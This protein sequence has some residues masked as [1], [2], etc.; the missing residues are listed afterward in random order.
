MIHYDITSLLSG[1]NGTG[2]KI[3]VDTFNMTNKSFD[4]RIKLI[5]L[6]LAYDDG[7]DDSISYFVNSNQLWS[8][9]DV[10]V[11]FDTE[12][13]TDI[14]RTS[15]TNIVLSSGDGTYRMND[16]L[17]GDASE[18][19]T[20]N[21]FYYQYNK[22]NDVTSLIKASQKNTLNVAY[23]GTSTY[24][25]IKNVISVLTVN[26]LVADLSLTTEYTSVPCAYAGTNNT[27]T[28]TVKTNKAGQY[29]VKL[30]ADGTMVSQSEANLT[31][32]SNTVFITDPTVRAVDETTV[33]GA[34][35]NNV[36][37]AVQLVYK[38]ETLAA[39]STILPI[40]YNG[41]LGKDLAYPAGGFD[42]A[43]E[44]IVNGDI[45]VDVKDASSYLGTS[46]MNRTD[47]WAVNLDENSTVVK[48]FVYIPYNWFNGKLG[49]EDVNMFNVTFNG[50][51]VTPIG[52]YRDQGNLGKYGTYGYGV[53]V[54][55][56]TDLVNKSGD[57]TLTL[58]KNQATPA[59][60]PSVLVYMYDKTESNTT[61]QI[62]IVNGADLISNDYNKAGRI[63]KADSTIKTYSKFTNNATLYVFAAG[64]QAGEGN[65]VFNGETYEN[66]WSG[67]DKTTDL[68]T[69]NVTGN[70]KD[71]NAVSF[72]GTGS[73][74]LA[75][76]QMIV[77]TKDSDG[78]SVSLAP[79]YT[80]VPCVYAGTNNAITITIDVIKSGKY[81]VSLYDGLT[82][83]VNST[84][85]DL[86]TGTNKVVLIDPTIRPV[87]ETTVNGAKNK[88]VTYLVTLLYENK[89][90]ALN[91]TSLPILYNG[92]LGKDLEYNAK[93]IE[94]TTVYIVSGN[95][96]ISPKDDST[97]MSAAATNRT[98][99][100]DLEL[101]KGHSFDTAFV[102]IAY[103]WDKSGASG[104]VFN[105]TFN[106]KT[107]TPKAHY[108][109]QSNLGKYG[110]YGYGLFVY[111]VS[112]LIKEGNN[113]LVLNKES[114]LTAVYPSSL[115]FLTNAP[116]FDKFISVYI[117][118]GA[119]LISN[120]NNNAGRLVA[121]HSKFTEVDASDVKGAKFAVFAA[122]A[123]AGD[124]NIVFNG[125]E[126]VNVWNGT[127]NSF[128]VYLKD[129]TDSVNQTNT[130]SF[131][132]TG[133]TILAL[134]QILVVNQK[135]LLLAT[136]KALSTT[137]DS[138]KSFTVTVTDVNEVPMAGVK[139]NIAVYTNA[140]ATTYHAT[141]NAKG[142]A[143]LSGASRLAIGT[144]KVVI[145]I[146]T[147]DY[148][149]DTIT[150]AIKVAKAKTIVKAPKVTAKVKK[151]KYFKV[152]VI[153]KATKKAVKG[154]K[155]KV[156]VYTGKKYKTYTIKTKSKGIA[157]LNT[158]YFKV[159]THKVIITSGNAK[160]TIAA[161]SSIVIKK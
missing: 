2:L 87:N 83:K 121:T 38:D 67:T 72:V 151:S 111:D 53:L 39:N 46:A 23:A 101:P 110:N 71:S 100:W 36:T 5:A 102:Y 74:I 28:V 137:Y 45:V 124:G 97:Y 79:E 17:I 123:N 80:S 85:V 99:V 159:G 106:G 73:T 155:V 103:N 143:T 64:A 65:I 26:N 30:F 63:V 44:F 6:V 92:N 127:S 108:R 50:A 109:D 156:K 93:Y 31:N 148:Y 125:V 29:A 43:I 153:N 4:G 134:S 11:T 88:N 18:H 81:T 78:A 154:I 13:L 126:D 62:Y 7:D 139:L 161:K 117:A 107:I 136:P 149:M 60:Y 54:Y 141:T 10:N 24:G 90:A 1:L 82:K 115:L 9:S 96:G 16:E 147:S 144:H 94:N 35:N 113:T 48:S 52:I 61:K 146:G 95:V 130:V 158:K 22:W 120:A 86:I 49:T 152:K 14:G 76:P 33:S 105:V 135:A 34:E 77:L 59:V 132:G 69:V 55:D 131:V 20:G 58:N 89:T 98:D 47:V 133:S 21:D 138:G 114:G 15:L 27:L 129:V 119:D 51:N 116:T 19:S 91:Y 8:K 142:V 68:Y 112:D 150:S 145:T 25:S 140:K 37:Y 66:V 118:D 41:Y 84:E 57:N 42:D 157:Y 104:P 32:G 40:L 3:N 128:D 56:V 122:S 70:V 160:Y 75:L 12:T